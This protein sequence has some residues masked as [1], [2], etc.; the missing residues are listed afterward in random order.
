MSRPISTL[1][2][3]GGG[4]AG[5]LAALFFRKYLGHRIRINLV[6]PSNS[7][8]MS[9][10]E[11]TNGPFTDFLE[12][13]NITKEDIITHCD[14]TLKI[15]SEFVNWNALGRGYD[16]VHEF[17]TTQSVN[18]IPLF[19]YWHSLFRRGMTHESYQDSC[20]INANLVKKNLVPFV[21]ERLDPVF[22][23]GYHFDTHKFVNF[24]KGRATSEGVNYFNGTVAGVV[25]EIETNN[26][27]KVC[28]DN[29]EELVS[30]FYI[31]CSG[32]R[33]ALMS[34]A[35]PEASNFKSARSRLPCDSAVY[36]SIENNREAIRPSTKG[37]AL[38][39]GWCWDIPLSNRTSIGYV[40]A[41]DFCEAAAATAELKQEYGLSKDVD[42]K[43]M[44]WEPGYYDN[45][46]V[47]NCVAIGVSNAFIEPIESLTSA[48]LTL[49]LKRLLVN[50][51]NTSF[52][53]S[54][55]CCYND[56]IISQYEDNIDFISLHYLTATRN[57]SRFW[58]DR[59]SFMAVSDR[60]KELLVRFAKQAPYEI[61]GIYNIKGIVGML[62]SRDVVPEDTFPLLNYIGNWDTANDILT[63]K[64]QQNLN[65]QSLYMDHR[66]FL[67]NIKRDNM[68]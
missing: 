34:L 1:T 11:S 40:Y 61:N 44:G 30:D 59:D 55:I 29:G 15:A 13:L 56:S 37:T 23:Y 25:K 6:A 42:L 43:T 4:V 17:Q 9:V 54:S 45:P 20:F 68:G 18:G 31:D 10:G 35:Y 52:N 57:D 24:L 27:Q 21:N 66:S 48:T 5:W 7:L 19:Y 3:I 62:A 60:V 39:A 65:A 26:I 14:G 8:P 2:I 63:E 41:S 53:D 50:F 67:E 28:L 51:P 47:R 32:F 38:S 46:W 49:E 22:K 64:F 12:D 58:R 16:W 36:C 33:R